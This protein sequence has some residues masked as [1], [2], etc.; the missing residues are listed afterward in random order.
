MPNRC[1]ANDLKFYVDINNRL[2]NET[3]NSEITTAVFDYLQN[4]QNPITRSR[5]KALVSNLPIP[6]DDTIGSENN[7]SI[8]NFRISSDKPKV[9]VITTSQ[10]GV[11]TQVGTTCRV[12]RAN[13][14]IMLQLLL[15]RP[16]V[17]VCSRAVKFRI[18][19]YG[20]MKKFHVQSGCR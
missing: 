4:L 3:V 17:E 1:H 11:N 15:L 12:T 14:V 13:K 20:K 7:I 19:P 2:I 8:H 6:K 10:D 18:T 9:S 16:I 5:T